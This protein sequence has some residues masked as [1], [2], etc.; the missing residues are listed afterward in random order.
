M[1]AGSKGYIEFDIFNKGR[2]PA[3]NLICIIDIKKN[4][5]ELSF[6]AASFVDVLAPGEHVHIKFPITAKISAES[7]FHRFTV[8]VR[9][10]FGFDADDKIINVEVFEIS[11]PEFI[12]DSIEID[13][14][15]E[16]NS[17][18]NSNGVIE[19]GETIELNI[20]IKNTGRGIAENF[21]A[22]LILDEKLR[23]FFLPKSNNRVYTQDAVNPGE[24][25]EMSLYFY[26]N[27]KVKKGKIP[28]SLE[29]TEKTGEFSLTQELNLDIKEMSNY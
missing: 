1:A 10:Y 13:D 8:S 9:E 14:D 17:L 25:L 26:T 5:P 29:V 11:T 4:A 23:G 21:R 3:Y 28:L 20:K 12:V 24:V 22:E 19:K 27:K 15:Q 16:G 18:G 2:G 6:E 7:K